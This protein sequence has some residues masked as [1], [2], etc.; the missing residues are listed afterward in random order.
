[1]RELYKEF[2]IETVKATRAINCKAE[3]RGQLSEL[4]IMNY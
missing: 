4:L 3:K 1:V 2:R